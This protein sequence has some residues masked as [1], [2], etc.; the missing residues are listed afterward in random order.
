M[1]ISPP[2]RYMRGINGL[3][4]ACDPSIDV[5]DITPVVLSPGDPGYDIAG[6]A[7]ATTPSTTTTGN[8]YNSFLYGNTG[9]TSSTS[10][11]G[12]TAQ[13]IAALAPVLTAA[14][15][16]LSAAT[17]PYQI[18]GTNYIYNPATGQILLNGAAVGTYNPATGALASL[19]SSITSYLPLIL[20]FG[21]IMLLVS[22]LG[23]KK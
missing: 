11:S 7:P 17:G 8:A 21:A 9:T 2:L 16:A 19:S 20:G 15:K 14:S 22:I 3:G 13:D 5:C 23:G 4:Q 1:L 6:N 18:S 12:L 10:S